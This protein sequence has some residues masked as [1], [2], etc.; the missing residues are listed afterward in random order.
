MN[1]GYEYREQIGAREG[2][3]TVLAHLVATRTHSGA[4]DWEARLAAGEVSV[5]GRTAAPGDVLRAGDRLSWRRPPWEEP[6]APVTYA[7]L[8]EDGDVLAVAKPRGL[9]AVPAGGFLENTLLHAV[10]QV[11]P[12]ATPM[13]RLGRGTSG[14]MVFARTQGARRALAAAWRAG[15]VEKVYRALVC[16]SPRG[17]AFTV[18]TPI[19]L[20][21]H[22]RLG[23]VHAAAPGGKP[24]VSHAKV[25]SRRATS[26]LVE[27]TIPTGRPHQIR[28]HLAA[29]GHPLAGDP[30]YAAG[31]RARA[32]ALPG[33]GGYLLHA[34][35][36]AFAHPAHGARVSIECLPPPA[37]RD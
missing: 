37:L 22:P 6:E 27:V 11:Y 21:A 12:E 20:V 9:P 23:R 3:R 28:I 19:G 18:E 16:G 31:G 2:G 30:L 29:A 1:D 34:V 32:D 14:V 24:A 10:R 15:A 13:H 17:D 35:R 7:V 26:T 5:G 25:L 4:A 8:H 36:I 33:D